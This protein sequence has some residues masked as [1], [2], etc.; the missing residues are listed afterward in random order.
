MPIELLLKKFNQT[1]NVTAIAGNWQIKYTRSIKF[2]N[3]SLIRKETKRKHNNTETAQTATGETFRSVL[4]SVCIPK[5]L[6][7]GIT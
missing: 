3:T 5:A 7:S 1:F 6:T 4:R 2:A